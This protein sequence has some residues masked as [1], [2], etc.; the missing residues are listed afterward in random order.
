MTESTARPSRTEHDAGERRDCVSPVRAIREGME[1]VV[2]PPR[3]EAPAA[4]RPPVE[5]YLGTEP[6][7]YRANRVFVWSIE[8]VRDPGREVRIHLMSE[9]PGFNRRL[10]TTGFTNFRFAIPAL[11]GGQGRAIYNDEDQIYLTD[12]GVLFDQTMENAALLSISDSESSV[13]LIDCARMDSVWTLEDA[14]HAWKRALLR[15]ASKQAGLRG[16]L[17][18]AWNARDEEFKPGESHLLHYTTL[19]TQPWRPFPERFVY[20]DGAYTNLWHELEREAI[21]QGFELFNRDAPSRAFG[22]RLQR[23]RALPRSEMDSGIGVSGELAGAVEELARRTKAS[24]L[25]ELAPDLRGDTEQRPGRYGLDVERRIGLLEWLGELDGEADFDGVVSVEGL[26]ALPIWDI[27]WIIESLF[28]R[29]SR[30]VFVAVRCP[31]SAPR[32]R[33]L[34]PPA[35]P[36]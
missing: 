8:K 23:L 27:P 20:W 29:A 7:Q 31:E 36:C 17:D 10:W 22:A 34:L 24:S 4:D 19:H 11:A 25:L 30:F 32:R 33:F 35:G 28:E 6:A 14:Q 18:P 13:M 16:D 9:M 5:I 1:C 2:L 26:E 3:S 12:P 21:A 15:R